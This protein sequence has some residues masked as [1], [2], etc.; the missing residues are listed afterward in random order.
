MYTNDKNTATMTTAMAVTL[1]VGS[2][3]EMSKLVQAIAGNIR[4]GKTVNVDSMGPI[5]TFIANK[6]LV[7]A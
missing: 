2:S 1:K 7:Y 6:A 3:T 4:S 5:A